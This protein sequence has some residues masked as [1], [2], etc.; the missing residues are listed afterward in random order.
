L[1]KADFSK[2]QLRKDPNSR[3]CKACVKLLATQATSQSSVQSS[4]ET[5][6]PVP[7]PSP[8]ETSAPEIV[9]EVKPV[10]VVEVVPSD[11]EK[12]ISQPAVNTVEMSQSSEA[13]ECDEPTANDAVESKPAE[14]SSDI[15]VEEQD[16]EMHI[17]E[18]EESSD[19]VVEESSDIVVE[20]EQDKEKDIGE[21]DES[22]DIVVEKSSGI[23]V[24]E[25]DREIHI[26]ESV[27]VS[28]TSDGAS[29][30]IE[31]V[32]V[33]A[34][35]GGAFGDDVG[36]ESLEEMV[37]N[38]NTT[39]ETNVSNKGES[40]REKESV[41]D[42]SKIPDEVVNVKDEVE[43]EKNK[44]IPDDTT[45]PSPPPDETTLP[46]P[47]PAQEIIK[48][49]TAEMVRVQEVDCRETES[50]GDLSARTSNRIRVGIC[51][52]DKKARS[53]PMVSLID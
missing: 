32:N 45:I 5:T 18:S 25:Q 16:K 39:K 23:V 40:E 48:V 43:E 44:F 11:E 10:E 26:G 13:A 35:S 22:S 29:G 34:T 50:V 28:V 17:E 52:M 36:S 49:D 21:S 14:E 53:K 3:R 12:D 33:P 8:S 46:S 1:A 27:N 41:P 38:E 31:Y 4:S 20:E 19:I 42:D 51:A 30:I 37:Q 24:E 47:P 9:S 2:N 15:V 6:V 7:V